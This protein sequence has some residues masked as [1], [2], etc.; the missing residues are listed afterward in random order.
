MIAMVAIRIGSQANNFA[1]VHI[2]SSCGFVTSSRVIVIFKYEEN[3][4]YQLFN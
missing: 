3:K 2:C 4:P 1:S